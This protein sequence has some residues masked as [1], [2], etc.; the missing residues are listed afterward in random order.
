[1]FK[2]ISI[3][4]T[5]PEAIKM[6]VLH[7]LMLD[8]DKFNP[9][10]CS[11][12]QHRELLSQALTQFDITPDFSFDAIAHNRSL[13]EQTAYIIVELQK[14]FEKENPEL[15]IVQGDTLSAYCGALVGFYNKIKIAH[16]EA[17][18]RT[19]NKFGPFPE[20][21]NRVYIDSVADYHFVPTDMA[22][23]NLI[24]EKLS[25]EYI[26][27]TGNTGID[28]L[29][30]MQNKN[31]QISPPLTKEL[32]A[33]LDHSKNE[34]KKIALLTLHRRETPP[35]LMSKIVGELE[36]VAKD[37][38]LLV[39]FP[40]H[41]NPEIKE[42]LA[43]YEKSAQI[44]CIPA[45]AYNVFIWL[46]DQANIIY[47][48]SGGIQEEATSMGKP[49]LVLRNETERQEILTQASTRLSSVNSLQKDTVWALNSNT[50]PSNLFGEGLAS[51]KIIK[52]LS[53]LLPC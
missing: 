14:L 18:L 29:K 26:F 53:Q 50:Q 9:K 33:I 25:P 20:E 5:R 28:A 52:A 51:Q 17:G 30:F 34:N 7:R 44:K 41:P 21:I 19:W 6:A 42:S 27:T 46:M 37:Q 12:G 32:S 39:I 40:M 43:S 1:M 8:D 16:V 15:V 49:L 4:G 24:K 36:Q 10:L 13:S 38:N 22:R 48:D 2:V 11:T 45:Q 31:A 3:I 47:T 23:T 35:A